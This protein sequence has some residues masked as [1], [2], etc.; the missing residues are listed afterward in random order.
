MWCEAAWDDAKGGCKRQ[1]SSGRAPLCHVKRSNQICACRRDC[2]DRGPWPCT[3]AGCPA[4]QVTCAIL[5]AACFSQFSH[6]WNTAPSSVAE[7]QVWQVCPMSCGRCLS[8]PQVS[9]EIPAPQ[10]PAFVYAKGVAVGAS[11]GQM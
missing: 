9:H 5:S 2:V 11:L 8:R 3:E 10:L 6:I 1:A 7:L 4:R